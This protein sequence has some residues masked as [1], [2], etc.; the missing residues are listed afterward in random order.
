MAEI[1]KS[2]Q[3]SRSI[4]SEG[5]EKGN[6]RIITTPRPNTPPPSQNPKKQLDGKR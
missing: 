4:I 1:T 3:Q 6:N 2:K 5:S